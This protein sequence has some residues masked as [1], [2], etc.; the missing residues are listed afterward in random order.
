MKISKITAVSVLFLSLFSCA[1]NNVYL[2]MIS[3]ANNDESRIVAAMET[4]EVFQESPKVENEPKYSILFSDEI[5]EKNDSLVSQYGSKN[6]VAK[7]NIDIIGR[8]DKEN[9]EKN[10]V[11]AI[12][13]ELKKNNKTINNKTNQVE[14]CPKPTENMFL[15]VCN[16]INASKLATDETNFS[17]KYQEDLWKMS[18]AEVGKDTS[19][20]AKQKIQ[21]MWNTYRT[22]FKCPGGVTDS[23]HNG[24]VTKYAMDNQ[25]STFVVYSIKKYELDMNFIDPRDG[26]TLLDFVEE[27]L[28]MWKKTSFTSKT[29]EYQRVYDLLIKTGAKRAKDLK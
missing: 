25:F 18:C 20:T 1:S 8:S 5:G 13:S 12:G 15:T 28:E 21:I 16:S 6:T 14:K 22:E 11:S 3:A 23:I 4:A 19:E 24:N 29:N 10:Y 27:Q 26:K 17:Y 9:K 2:S 7:L